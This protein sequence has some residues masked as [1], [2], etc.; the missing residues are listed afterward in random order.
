[1]KSERYADFRLKWLANRRA[2]KM[3]VAMAQVKREFRKAVDSMEP[4]EQ[5]APGRATLTR[6]QFDAIRRAVLEGIKALA[7][8]DPVHSRRFKVLRDA[9]SQ[10]APVV[11]KGRFVI[12]VDGDGS[13]N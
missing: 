12:E 7:N 5:E 1:M 8:E 13:K 9:W 6:E 11:T 2:E 4:E 10:L 3:T